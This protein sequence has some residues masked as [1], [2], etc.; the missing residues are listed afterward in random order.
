MMF[1][2]MKTR[3]VMALTLALAMVLSFIPEVSSRAAD[4]T[5]IS[6]SPSSYD[7]TSDYQSADTN[8]SDYI[9]EKKASFDSEINSLKTTYPSATVYDYS[10]WFDEDSGWYAVYES[11]SITDNTLTVK[12]K[13]Y[14]VKLIAQAIE[15]VSLT[16]TA[17]KVGDVIVESGNE[18]SGPATSVE[19]SANYSVKNR[20][21]LNSEGGYFNGTIEEGKSY[22]AEI[23]VNPNSGYEFSSTTTVT[24]KGAE[25]YEIEGK[26]PAS[27]VIKVT[28]VPTSDSTED[29][30]DDTQTDDGTTTDDTQ[31]DDSTTTDDTQTD[32][33]ITTD[34]TGN[35]SEDTTTE[36]AK[37]Y[38]I[39][40]GDKQSV[41][42]ESGKDLV[43]RA[44]GALADF[45]ELK[46]DGAVVDKSNYTLTEGS[47]IVT[48]KAAYL[49]TLKAGAHTLTFVYTDGEVS[50]SF[51]TVKPETTVTT[52]TTTEDKKEDKDTS[53]KTGDTD[54]LIYGILML[55]SLLGMAALCLNKDVIRKDR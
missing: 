38:T 27:I 34:D 37:T 35:D 23:I 40:N 55:I 10:T 49:D 7:F 14:E 50:A 48:V 19:S 44:N 22:D 28:V 39:L 26:S 11:Y 53:P 33:G 32:D 4:V 29:E 18:N 43:I 15:T 9:A 47:T 16:V 42:A 51:T 8:I 21:Y 54:I 3:G 41:T 46:I 13:L 2:K 20:F 12:C 25:S 5:E 36:P 6:V 31:T 30:T 52:T 17:P 45:T 1:K 24:V